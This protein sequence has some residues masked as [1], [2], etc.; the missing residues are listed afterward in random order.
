MKQHRK[1][2][3]R[4]ILKNTQKG[5]SLLEVLIASS[6]LAIS[7]TG[8]S[9]LQNQVMEQTRRTN[10]RA[11][12]TQKATQMFEEL[13]NFVQANRE[14]PLKSLQ[15]YFS[16]GVNEFVPTLTTEKRIDPAAPN[17]R[18]QDQ[19]LAPNDILSANTNLTPEASTAKW[20]YVRQVLVEPVPGDVDA[21]HVTVKVWYANSANQPSNED[22]PLAVITGILKTNIDQTPPTEVYDMYIMAMENA[23]GWWVDVSTLRP[24]FD[25]T[26]DDL[27]SRNPGLEIRKHYLNRFGFGRDPYYMPYVNTAADSRD[28]RFPFTYFY[29]GNIADSTD[30]AD[31]RVVEAYVDS[32]M[33]GRKRNDVSTD[34]FSIF[35]NTDSIRPN[36][37]N[38][39]RYRDYPMADQYN[40]SMRHA[41]ET[42]MF[43]RLNAQ[44]K[45]AGG[46]GTKDMEP[47]LRLLLDGMNSDP[48]AFRSS[49]LINLHG[50]LVPLPPVRNYSDPAKIPCDESFTTTGNLVNN[51]PSN[52]NACVDPS[53]SFSSTDRT[54]ELRYRNMRVVTHPE[55]IAYANNNTLNLRVYPYQTVPL[56]LQELPAVNPVADSVEKISLFIPTNGQGKNPRDPANPGY[57]SN[58]SS[59][60]SGNLAT[61]T[62]ALS[63]TKIVGS[64]TIA[65]EK[66]NNLAPIAA[67]RR[68]TALTNKDELVMGSTATNLNLGLS[69][70]PVDIPALNNRVQLVQLSPSLDS[71]ATFGTGR[72]LVQANAGQKFL[73]MR[74]KNN[75]TFTAAEETAL[76]DLKD[77]LIVIDAQIPDG[78]SVPT[79]RE[80]AR[81]KNILFNRNQT[82][83]HR[84]TP[85][86]NLANG[87]IEIELYENL[88]STHQ[89]TISGQP[90][91]FVAKHRDYDVATSTLSPHGIATPGVRINLY[92]TMSRHPKNGNGG[93]YHSSITD[94]RRLYRQEYI[95]MAVSD[96]PDAD[97]NPDFS[98]DLTDTANSGNDTKNTARW[99]VGL[100][101]NSIPDLQNQRITV[102]TRIGRLDDS[103]GS[104]A[105][106]NSSDTRLL[107]QGLSADGDPYRPDDISTADNEN[108]MIQRRNLY[109]VSRTY[110]WTADTAANAMAKVPMSERYQFMG[111]PRFMPYA[112]L[113]VTQGQNPY[114][115]DGINN[116]GVSGF[117]TNGTGGSHVD[118]IRYGR[119][120]TDGLMRSGSI[121]NSIS[122]YSNYY[123]A[124]GGDM[125][126]D[127]NN[128]LYNIHLQPFRENDETGNVSISNAEVADVGGGHR[129]K[130]TFSRR[131]SADADRWYGIYWQGDLFPD[132]EFL[133]WKFNG[134]LPTRGFTNA[135]DK[136]VGITSNCARKNTYWRGT[137]STAPLGLPNKNK[138]PG[139]Q[140]SPTFMNGNTS[141]S[142]DNNFGHNS[143]DA[144]RGKLTNIAGG[145]LNRSFNLSLE[146][147][148][149]SA[150]PFVLN[151]A[152]NRPGLYTNDI[153]MRNFRNKLEVI[154][155]N[156]GAAQTTYADDNVF[157][158]KKGDTSQ[159]S[160]SI[161]KLSRAGVGSGYMLVNGLSKTE[162][163]SE[164]SVARFSIAGMLQAYMNGG[165]IVGGIGDDA[166]RTRPIPRVEV[167]S[168]TPSDIFED[169]STI[170]VKFVTNWLRWDLEK[171][172]PA[173]QA[174]WRDTVKTQ[175][176]FKYSEDAG[177]TWLYLDGTPSDPEGV[178]NSAKVYQSGSIT[179]F[180]I[181][182]GAAGLTQEM[183]WNVSA[184]QG[185]YLLRVECHRIEDLAT[186]AL[187]NG[188]SYHQVYVTFRRN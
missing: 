134:N 11:F 163:S 164:T 133:F 21:R 186:T 51:T 103:D 34:H 68:F 152:A 107:E 120:F 78:G 87:T 179:K 58:P 82:G 31:G 32:L 116:N 55:Q 79:V 115:V 101:L 46:P 126:A 108:D 106:L 161:V 70:S 100:N 23:P 39:N 178:Y 15:D 141:G 170:K 10:D 52:I 187:K 28:T 124:L 153:F 119:L 175:Y 73:Y 72:L 121:Y 160:S 53:I 125:G 16:N 24:I 117:T 49:M 97:T 41:D 7:V 56:G 88:K 167:T 20:K 92:D 50:E 172:S 35:K 12:A 180:D 158:F 67:N 1:S 144:A 139:G 147:E 59:D 63:L 105:G 43:Q 90:A 40:Q 45:A 149:K 165:D 95:P 177:K 83:N 60:P 131:D 13:R 138:N 118:F 183:D 99:V 166:A 155:V 8:V 37:D 19:Y 154:N 173:Y 176:I 30:S 96:G 113:R 129:V 22:A 5:F 114:F 110:A 137:A 181:P 81:V 66:E 26:I 150:R 6:I 33:E 42:S 104:T 61:Y 171:Y 112:D 27:S 91:A 57:L 89:L 142:G 148:P 98:K 143:D 80:V 76:N 130:Y 69:T 140:G 85:P 9:T 93:L 3:N 65:Y 36:P 182:G 188:Y 77:G 111:D 185:T 86:I 44:R 4:K 18:R 132:E 168:P 38:E 109:N 71:T 75:T 127:S 14:E 135:N 64:N 29:P 48:D 174:S 2:L 74:I 157:Y 17:N 84:S 159:L 54:R 122:G 146:A 136:C 25:R 162:E 47:S 156:T 102:E 94:T 128:T 145:N 169:A 184:L 62:S 151:Q 123:Y